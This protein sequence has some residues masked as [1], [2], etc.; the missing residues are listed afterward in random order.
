MHRAPVFLTLFHSF[1]VPSKM[2]TR[3]PAFAVQSAFSNSA[4]SSP[5]SDSSTVTST[6]CGHGICRQ[7]TLVTLSTAQ[8]QLARR[9]TPTVRSCRL[10]GSLK[11]PWLYVSGEV[12]ASPALAPS[13]FSRSHLR[14]AGGTCRTPCCRKQPPPPR[15]VRSEFKLNQLATVTLGATSTRSRLPRG[16]EIFTISCR[17]QV[18]PYDPS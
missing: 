5:S 11:M 14:S 15:R 8:P 12:S 9:A 1:A 10:G 16:I 6:S 7:L 13:T 18:T 4:S 17:C 3:L 2:N